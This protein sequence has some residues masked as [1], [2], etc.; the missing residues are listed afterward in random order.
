MALPSIPCSRLEDASRY[1]R[2]L[3]NKP[4]TL[5]LSSV[6]LALTLSLSVTSIPHIAKPARATQ[7]TPPSGTYFDHLVV[8]IM[9]DN[10]IYDVCG[11]SPL[12]CLRTKGATFMAG[13]TNWC[14]IGVPI[15]VVSV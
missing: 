2:L 9:E 5:I 12:P 3:R 15:P 1:R 14:A 7:A 13:L 4:A 10:G 6:L 8:V 11:V